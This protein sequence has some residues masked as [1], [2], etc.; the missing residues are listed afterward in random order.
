MQK[1]NS[2]LSVIYLSMC[3]DKHIYTYNSNLEQ[4]VIYNYI[5]SYLKKTPHYNIIQISLQ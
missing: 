3:L 5:V 2:H 1:Q 4:N